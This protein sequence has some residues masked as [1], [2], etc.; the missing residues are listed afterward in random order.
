LHGDFNGIGKVPSIVF[1]TNLLD[2]MT[3]T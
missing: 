3:I 1:Q 2:E